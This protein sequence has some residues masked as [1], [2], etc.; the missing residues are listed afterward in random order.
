MKYVLDE[1][2]VSW[3][4]NYHNCIVGPKYIVKLPR[5]IRVHDQ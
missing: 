3:T 5:K 2:T 4:E 1:Q